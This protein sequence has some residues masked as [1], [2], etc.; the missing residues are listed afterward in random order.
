MQWNTTKYNKRCLVTPSNNTDG[1][2]PDDI[3]IAVKD[4][5]D[6]DAKHDA[7]FVKHLAKT[8]SKNKRYGVPKHTICILADNMEW[9]KKFREY[10][11]MS[12]TGKD[13]IYANIRENTYW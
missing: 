5:L 3:V 10:S 9:K 7:M 8:H 2:L 12:Q 1:D 4:N 6:R 13:I 11:P